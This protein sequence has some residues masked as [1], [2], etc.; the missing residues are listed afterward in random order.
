VSIRSTIHFVPITPGGT[1]C[2]W[3]ASSTREEAIKKLLKD[4]EHMPYKTW[5]N[6]EKR[7]YT[8]EKMGWEDDE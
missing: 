3:L 1:A 8:I 4:A 7:G 5:A 6:F 2:I